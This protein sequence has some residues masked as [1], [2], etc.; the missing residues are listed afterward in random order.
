[1]INLFSPFLSL[2]LDGCDH[3]PELYFAEL[4]DAYKDKTSY[5]VGSFVKYKCQLG[6]TKKTKMP[7]SIQCLANVKWS[8]V[9]VLCKSKSLNILVLVIRVADRTDQ[10]FTQRYSLLPKMSLNRHQIM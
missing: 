2:M 6:Y 10:S 9:P 3:P 8:S 7:F 5:P 4:L 1:M